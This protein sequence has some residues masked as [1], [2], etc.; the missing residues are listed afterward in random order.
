LIPIYQKQN[1][2][3]FFEDN[4]LNLAGD[5]KGPSV[6]SCR[7]QIPNVSSAPNPEARPFSSDSANIQWSKD[8]KAEQKATL[9]LHLLCL[10]LPICNLP[11]PLK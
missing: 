5:E 2:S 9:D 11:F 7:V 6:L 4:L 3:L 8:I 1:Y 10:Q